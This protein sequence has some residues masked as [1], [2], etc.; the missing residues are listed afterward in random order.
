MTTPPILVLEIKSIRLFEVHSLFLWSYNLAF[1]INFL[2][3][4]IDDTELVTEIEC[5]DKADICI[6][7][8]MK[9]EKPGAENSI[10]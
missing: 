4:L 5:K 7:F 2:N 8:D 3:A 6:V 1:T 9:V 10:I